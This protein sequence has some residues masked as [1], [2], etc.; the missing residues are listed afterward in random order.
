MKLSKRTFAVLWGLVVAVFFTG[1]WFLLIHSGDSAKP[2]LLP[3]QSPLIVVIDELK[4][5]LFIFFG[6][7]VPAALIVYWRPNKREF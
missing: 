6:T 3:G 1:G 2:M 4:T 7:G 5:G